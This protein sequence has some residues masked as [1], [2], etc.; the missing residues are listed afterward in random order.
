MNFDETNLPVLPNQNYTM[1]IRGGHIVKIIGVD[2]KRNVTGVVAAVRDGTN[3]SLASYISRK[4]RDYIYQLLEI[5][6]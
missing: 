3:F 2:D 6:H 5:L 1:N 4:N